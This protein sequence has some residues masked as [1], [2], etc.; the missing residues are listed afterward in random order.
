LF[1]SAT[2]PREAPRGTASIAL[3]C[4]LAG[5]SGIGPDHCLAGSGVN[6]AAL[7]DPQAEVCAGQELRVIANFLAAVEDPEGLG[8]DAGRRYRLTTYGIWGFALLSSRTAREANAVAN[9][10]LDLT[11]ALTRIGDREADGRLETCFEDWDFDEPV[12]RFVLERDSSAALTIWRELLEGP[13]SPLR[14]ELR[15]PPPRRPERFRAA[16]GVLPE[17]GSERSVM[18]LDARLLDRPLPRAAPLTAKAAADQCRELLE[19]RQ[20]RQGVSARVRDE[21]LRDPQRMPSQEEL[22]AALHVSVRT[23]RRQLAAEGTSFRR[24]VEQ[25]REGLA[26]ELLA[27]GR[28]TVEQVAQRIGYSEASSFV[29]AFTR[30]KGT[31]PRRWASGAGGPARSA[32]SVRG[33]AHA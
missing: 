18:T 11:Y 24:L 12:R 26:E 16:Y 30:W 15:L 31:A 17:F 14:V 10:F 33:R 25:V 29:H 7:A 32:G 2:A 5:E 22:A 28:M 21:L 20:R 27:T 13:V 1:D 19:R 3:L 23:L 6:P 4:A 8:L 9:Q